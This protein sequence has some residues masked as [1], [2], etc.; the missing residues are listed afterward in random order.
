MA[1]I[2]FFPHTFCL[3]D[4]KQP[5]LLAYTCDVF[6]FPLCELTIRKKNIYLMETYIELLVLCLVPTMYGAMYTR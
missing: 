1:Y 6:H 2:D 5:C 3:N 4:S